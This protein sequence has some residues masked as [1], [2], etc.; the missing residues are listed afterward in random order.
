MLVVLHIAVVAIIPHLVVA[1]KVSAAVSAP[2][3]AR[4]ASY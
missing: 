3:Q 2:K 4:V 1:T